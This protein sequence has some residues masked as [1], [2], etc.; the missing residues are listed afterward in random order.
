MSER[1]DGTTS[2]WESD[3]DLWD[4]PAA[5]AGRATGHGRRRRRLWWLLTVP[6]VVVLLLAVGLFGYFGLTLDGSTMVR[7]RSYTFRLPGRWWPS[8]SDRGAVQNAVD[9]YRGPSTSAGRLHVAVTRERKTTTLRALERAVSSRVRTVRGGRIVRPVSRVRLGGEQAIQLD[10]EFS[11]DGTR[12][13]TRQIL[14]PHDGAVYDVILLAVPYSG[15]DFDQVAGPITQQVLRTWGW[16][17][18]W[19]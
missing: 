10:Y 11:D 13:L 9:F 18:R 8:S 2:D 4:S 1:R 19:T 15:S 3:W 12:V 16:G 5:P 17:W 6:A 14:C 7:D